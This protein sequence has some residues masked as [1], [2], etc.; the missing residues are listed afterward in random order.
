MCSAEFRA[1]SAGALELQ[2]QSA[3]V[4]LRAAQIF[5]RTASL[6]SF[7]EG[8]LP[9]LQ[10]HS[11]PPEGAGLRFLALL[12]QGW[13]AIVLERIDYELARR[14]SEQ[15]D[16]EL[17][18]LD[19]DGARLFLQTRRF[20]RGKPGRLLTEPLGRDVEVVAW[21]L[22]ASL[23]VPAA[24]RLL[25]LAAVEPVTPDH[26]EALPALLVELKPENIELWTVGAIPPDRGD[27]AP[28]EPDV[29]V[30][31]AAGESRALEVRRLPAVPATARLAEG[32]VAIEEAQAQRIARKLAAVT[33]AERIPKPTF[34]YELK[35]AGKLEPL[36]Q[37]ARAR[38]PWLRQLMET[39]PLSHAG[40]SARCRA[41][42][43]EELGQQVA[44]VHGLRL[45]LSSGVRVP[46]GPLYSKYLATLGE[47]LAVRS[48]L[49]AL[50]PRLQ[51][52]AQVP[53][54]REAFLSGLLPVVA[55]PSLPSERAS[56][57]V[58][59]DLRAA[60]IHD[61]GGRI[62]PVL[63]EDLVAVGV[64]LEDAF[65]RAVDAL[66]ARTIAAP[67]GLTWF[68]LEHGRAV[69]SDFDDAAGAARLLTPKG[70]EMILHILG[71]DACLAAAPTRDTL[72]A[73]AR[74]D[75]DAVDWLREEAQRR[76]EEGP[77]PALPELFRLTEEG[78]DP[79]AEEDFAASG[80]S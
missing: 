13:A 58:A 52:R 7:A 46:L 24:L 12:D 23:G 67:E 35:A 74:G 49:D 57:E 59:G 70:R 30:E 40:F 26:A 33:D 47:E 66:D 2:V 54:V 1:S 64:E 15:V 77:F 25:P 8:L 75:P 79:V 45:E 29:V 36:L 10:E 27:E 17:L 56:A 19:L 44:R 38:R 53:R 22:L 18:T 14:L 62:L 32:L 43:E 21:E 63:S 78:V 37:G 51:Q 4:P 5:V 48:A 6:E 31:S 61:D 28:V 71:T 65:Q 39:A 11:R 34:A 72:L 55:G 73:C 60:L 80:E 41:A 20:N 69:V 9:A 3:P 76:F 50:R 68:D 16:E 42:I